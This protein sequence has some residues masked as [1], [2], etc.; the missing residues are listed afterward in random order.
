MGLL[1]AVERYLNLD[2]GA[3]GQL[4]EERVMVWNEGLNRIKGVKATRD[5][6]NEAGQPAPRTLVLLSDLSKDDIIQKLWNGEPRI[7]VAP[8][9]HVNGILLNPMTV[10]EGEAEI[11]LAK[12]CSLLS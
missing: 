2:H 4:F 6:P 11:V 12:L 10:Q 1:A 5:Y 9:E 8:A 3:R 7:A